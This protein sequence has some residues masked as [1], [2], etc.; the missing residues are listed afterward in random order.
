MYEFMRLVIMNKEGLFNWDIIAT[1]FSGGSLIYIAQT[2]REMRK[3]REY[4]YKP[5]V[6]FDNVK[7]FIQKN[8]YGIPNII[9]YTN[10]ISEDIYPPQ[11]FIWLN[12]VGIAT[13]TNIKIIWKFDKDNIISLYENYGINNEIFKTINDERKLQMLFKSEGIDSW[14]SFIEM[15]NN[16]EEIEIPFLKSN[17]KI[18]IRAPQEITNILSIE[19]VLSLRKDN[20]NRKEYNFNLPG[21]IIF[22]YKDLS[23][24]KYKALFSLFLNIYVNTGFGT[25][26]RNV[27]IVEL[28]FHSI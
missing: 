1:I 3:Q 22:E 12:N 9:K 4:S 5:L 7:A 23:G 26:N 19:P 13:A 2:L 25:N 10:E 16:S 11:F 24:K 15:K 6:L 18:A 17:D 21:N 27:S 20:N 14:Y 28:S 8:P